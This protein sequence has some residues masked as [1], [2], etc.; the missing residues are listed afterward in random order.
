[1][2]NTNIHNNPW[3]PTDEGDHYPSMKEWWSVETLFRTIDDNK[4]WSLKGTIAYEL[5]TPSC[6]MENILFD[7]TL[8]KCIIHKAVN[9]D[10]KKF[11]H[12]KD[13]VD[14]RYKNFTLTGLYPD[15][16]LHIEDE[17]TSF[18]TDMILKAKILPHW[19]AQDITNGYLPVGLG[20]FR[21]GWILNCDLTGTIT[22][23][24]EEHNIKG[25]GY[26]EHAWGNWSY[27]NPFKKFSDVKKTVSTYGRL[28]NWW[29][30]NHKL[31]IPEKI[32]F[33]SENN[34][35]GYDWLWGVFKNEWSFFYG[36]SLYWISEGPAFGVLTLFTEGNNYID[37]SDIR[38]RYN[39][40][41]YIKKYDLYYP[42]DVTIT[43]KLDD[44]NIK[45]RAQ[46]VCDPFEYVDEFKGDGFYKAFIM[47]EMPGRITG[48]YFDDEKT[49]KLEGDC[50]IE[51]QRQPSKLGH[52]SL[53][54]DFL[55][56]PKGVGVSFEL[57][58]HYLKKKLITGIQLIPQPTIMFNV[59][60]VEFNNHIKQIAFSLSDRKKSS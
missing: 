2:S 26:L 42:T 44:K 6:F 9:D 60:K 35:F 8:N 46:P 39:K 47:P 37:F 38:F 43:A 4:K 36:N 21:Y 15:Y 45:I 24:N 22:L 10:L 23:N 53:A 59:H 48:V 57:D 25:K 41:A 28:I 56:P 30:S 27:S 32:V 11:I 5:E 34:P 31:R 20:H 54:I 51:R 3:T 17:T 14:L 40:T 29:F 16:H 50:K 52:N 7:I 1:M 55:K 13:K 33:T 58:S 49:I 19:S 12:N 18:S